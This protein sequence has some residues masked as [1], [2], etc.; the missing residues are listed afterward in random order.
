MKNNTWKKG[1]VLGIIVLFIGASVIPTIS[2][3]IEKKIIENSNLEFIDVTSKIKDEKGDSSRNN[4]WWH[5]FHHDVMHTGFTSGIG[6]ITIPSKKWEYT[7]NDRVHSS[8]SVADIDNDGRA[9]VVFGSDDFNVYALDG[10][11]GTI[12]WTFGTSMEVSSSPALGDIDN[13]GELEVV[14]GSEDKH[15]YAL[16]GINGSEEWR[17]LTDSYVYASPALGDIDNDGIVEV[18]VPSGDKLYVLN[19]I[20]GSEEW[21]FNGSYFIRSSPALGDIDNDGEIEIVFGI[22][23]TGCIYALNGIDGS[24]LWRY[25]TGTSTDTPPALGDIDNDGEIEVVIS[26]DNNVYALDGATGTVEWTAPISTPYTYSCAAL[27]D[28]DNDGEVE[29]VVGGSAGD[30]VYKVY[31]LDGATGMEEWS[32]PT[33]NYPVGTAPALG[34]IDGDGHIEVVISYYLGIFSLDGA[35]GNEEW[36]YETEVDLASPALVDI[37]NDGLIEVICSTDESISVLDE[38]DIVPPYC[39]ISKPKE[40]GLYLNNDKLFDFDFGITIVIGLFNGITVQV[41]A[42]DGQTGIDKVKIYIDDEYCSDAIWNSDIGYYEYSLIKTHFNW[43]SLE[44]IAID[45]FNN[46]GSS[47]KMDILYFNYIL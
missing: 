15:V 47:G 31:A 39:S 20:N 34:D 3:N 13:D 37:D 12:E 40:G 23:H 30:E 28:I 46:E 22:H 19:G 43:L 10:E 36:W 33:N 26:S 27:G 42:N 2:G 17:F 6:Q 16:N 5:T 29:V 24:I 9:E 38:D 14:I 21:R 35:T 45:K 1:L 4:D 11:N 41:R 44:A 18:V 25:C 32:T 8:P 7:A